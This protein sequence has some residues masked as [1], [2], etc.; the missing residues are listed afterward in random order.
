MFEVSHKTLMAGLNTSSAVHFSL[1]KLTYTHT[2]CHN[3][4]V[5]AQ[6]GKTRIF[7]H[8]KQAEVSSYEISQQVRE[9]FRLFPFILF[10]HTRT[11]TYTLA[12]FFESISSRWRSLLQ[13]NV[14]PEDSWGFNISQNDEEGLCWL[15]GRGFFSLSSLFLVHFKRSFFA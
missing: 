5:A 13:S 9:R 1:E 8:S 14:S 15:C 6:W 3:H 2:V 4:S 7:S 12:V 10:P 11:C